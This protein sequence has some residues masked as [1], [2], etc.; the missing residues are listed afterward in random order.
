MTGQLK[1]SQTF[2]VFFSSPFKGLEEER[3]EL[4]RKYIPEIQHRCAEMGLQFVAVDM[5]WG[6]S[7]ESAQQ[8]QTVN[9][10]FREIDRSDMLVNFFGQRYGWQGHTDALLQENINMALGNYPWLD[11]FRDRSVTELELQHG[12]LNNPGQLPTVICF[13]DKTYDDVMK[14]RMKDKAINYTAENED[15]RD[16]LTELKKKAVESQSKALAV[17][18]DYPNPHEG[19]RLIYEAIIKHMK[20]NVLKQSEELSKRE[21]DITP[22]RAFAASRTAMYVGSQGHYNVLNNALKS[23]TSVG[24]QGHYDFLNNALKSGESDRTDKDK[25]KSINHVV[26]VGPAGSGKSSLLCNWLHTHVCRLPNVIAI[27]YYV[28]CAPSTRD[29][30]QLLDFLYGE[31][32]HHLGEGATA[33][34]ASENPAEGNDNNNIASSTENGVQE[35]KNDVSKE[36]SAQT[37]GKHTNHDTTTTVAEN[38]VS[39]DAPAAYGLDIK[40]AGASGDKAD[41][42]VPLIGG[43]N[44]FMGH[45]SGESSSLVPRTQPDDEASS[46]EPNTQDKQGDDAAK[47]DDNNANETATKEGGMDQAVT[48][49]SE[50]SG[51]KADE[52]DGKKMSEGKADE[53]DGKKMS[54]GKADETDGKKMSEGKADETDGK[55]MSEGKADGTETDG[56]SKT[57]DS[58]ASDEEKLYPSFFS[59]ALSHPLH[60]S[61]PPPPAP[62]PSVYPLRHYP[63]PL[64]SPP[65]SNLPMRYSRDQLLEIQPSTPNFELVNRLRELRL[66][67]G[68]PRKRGCRGGRKKLRS[69]QVVPSRNLHPLMVPPFL[70]PHPDLQ[71]AVGNAPLSSKHPTHLPT[72]DCLLSITP[73]MGGQPSDA[74]ALSPP[75]PLQQGGQSS[76]APALSPPSPLPQGSQPIALALSP[77]SPLPQDG[78]PS[79]APGLSPSSST[80]LLCPSDSTLSICHL[81]SQSA[82]KTA[83]AKETRPKGRELQYQVT[84]KLEKLVASGHTVI[85]VFDAI[86]RLVVANKTSQTLYWLPEKLCGGVVCVVSTDDTDQASLGVLQNER[87]FN[88][89]KLEPLD[90]AVQREV[91]VNTLKKSGKE[92]SPAQLQRVVT[93]KQTENPLF[94]KIVLAELSI[95]GYFRKLDE[96]IDSL[97]HLSGLV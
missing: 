97:I 70:Q 38:P 67:V 79:D 42:S 13:R 83:K 51:G 35:Q 28:G 27:P 53:T 84:V 18:L 34:D 5:R 21:K 36:N 96:K 24:N 86:N 7:A 69:I 75:S 59:P 1:N 61:S 33:K 88:V 12:F 48:D 11:N 14:G 54:E 47:S 52:T 87:S 4:T 31:L 23:E 66:G 72:T 91:C 60:Y 8:A 56:S 68:L 41:S 2:R 71:S 62:V 26:V 25:E 92:L 90:E 89:L 39:S 85:L 65:S 58:N 76:N 50:T 64:P 73:L 9:I 3:E 63:P 40:D 15:S 82:V 77:S 93:A 95:F 19:A 44:L 17:H 32:E 57:S 80:L 16:K 81:N 46:T 6:I 29:P 43:L 55:K 30:E 10:C 49:S 94:L 74:P 20:E 78:Q 37:D 22:H 45:Q